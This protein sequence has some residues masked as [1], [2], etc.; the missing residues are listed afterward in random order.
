MPCPRDRHVTS[1]CAKRW[2]ICNNNKQHTKRCSWNR[3]SF[4]KKLSQWTCMHLSPPPPHPNLTTFCP[5][6]SCWLG[7]GCPSHE[8]VPRSLNV[9]SNVLSTR[10]VVWKRM[11]MSWKTKQTMLIVPSNPT[12]LNRVTWRRSS[13]KDCACWPSWRCRLVTSRT[14]SKLLVM[15]FGPE[16]KLSKPISSGRKVCDQ[17]IKLPQLCIIHVA[18]SSTHTMT[19]YSIGSMQGAKERLERQKRVT[20]EALQFSREKADFVGKVCMY[21]CVDER[22]EEFRY[23]MHIRPFQFQFQFQ[24]DLLM[25]VLMCMIRYDSGGATIRKGD[26]RG[27]SKVGYFEDGG[28]QKGGCRRSPSG[29][30]S[31]CPKAAWIPRSQ[32][33]IPSDMHSSLTLDVRR[34]SIAV[35]RTGQSSR[36]WGARF[37]IRTCALEN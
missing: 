22:T 9:A 10:R 6:F 13:K 27:S 1:M 5:Y 26:Q 11:L 21:G 32:S 33:S 18:S 19:Y 15:A 36:T 31:W 35:K 37:R 34:Q 17:H 2:Y 23:G 8:G 30:K 25:S 16:W 24:I 28:C 7:I 29:K 14:H 4:K 12:T 3:R 20:G